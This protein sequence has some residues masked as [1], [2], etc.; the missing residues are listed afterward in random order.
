MEGLGRDNESVIWRKQTKGLAP[1]N[2]GARCLP[3]ATTQHGTIVHTENSE[4]SRAHSR[5]EPTAGAPPNTA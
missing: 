1:E 3:F 5:G 4:A 2:P